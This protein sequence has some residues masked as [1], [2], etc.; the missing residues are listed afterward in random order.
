MGPSALGEESRPSTT[1][2]LKSTP[3]TS[4]FRNP[5]NVRYPAYRI[6]RRHKGLL[7]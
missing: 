5:S 3:S 1:C 2:T 7:Y 6:A 4:L